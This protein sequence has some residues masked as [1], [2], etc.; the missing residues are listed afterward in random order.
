EN[1]ARELWGSPQA[2][3]GKRLR[4]FPSMPWHEVI[5]VVA[6]VRENGVQQ[7]A[8][9]I[10]YWPTLMSNLFGPGAV[11]TIRT[12]TFAVRTSRSG[13]EALRKDIEQA[14]WSLNSNL[15]LAAVR[16]MQVVYD[17]SLARTSFTL[18]MLAIAGSMALVLG[19]IGVYGVISFTVSQ[20]L[21][22]LGIRVALGAQPSALLQL[23]LVHGA[24]LALV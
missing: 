24:K 14:V 5:G 19:L 11:Q 16:T 4:E 23:L 6:D 17:K 15:P 12:A 18:V 9:E 2:A 10:V 1:L 13:T 3:L 7:V 8:P 21:R 20:R 22:E